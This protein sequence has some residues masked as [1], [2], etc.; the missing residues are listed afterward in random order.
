[1]NTP[2]PV[3]NS[4]L[5]AYK[6]ST[7]LV[8]SIYLFFPLVSCLEETFEAKFKCPDNSAMKASV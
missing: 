5:G 4:S 7:P 3:P 6:P 1:M 2:L 8:S